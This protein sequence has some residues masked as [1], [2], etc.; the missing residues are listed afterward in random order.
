[1]N[2]EGQP[3]LR[4]DNVVVSPDGI[5]E[6]H[7]NQ[8]VI[9]VPTDQVDRIT[10][11][12]GRSDHRPLATICIGLGMAVIG[13]VGLIGFILSPKG[14]RYELG[15]AACGLIGGSLVFDTLKQRFYFEIEKKQGVG[16]LIFSKHAQKEAVR[17][18]CVQIRSAY[19]YEITDTT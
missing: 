4:F 12:F 16:R 13:I 10:L 5:S 9:F 15:M 19:G 8:V 7:D 14:F 2:S 3:I 11:K 18:F 1:M 17:E 6:V